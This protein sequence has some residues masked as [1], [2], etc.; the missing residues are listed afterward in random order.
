MAGARKSARTRGKSDAI[1]ALA[2]ARAALREEAELHPASQDEAAREL[3]LLVD[4]RDALVAERTGALP[5]GCAGTCTTS[6]P[7]LEPP[8]RS[9]DQAGTRRSLSQRLARRERRVQVRICRDLLARIGDLTRRE[10]RS[11][12]RSASAPSATARRCSR[13]PESPRSP[14]AS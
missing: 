3:K 10:R 1:D 2:I 12:A 13:C 14:P 8:A 7:G 4:H 6:R 9:L 11:P 5:R